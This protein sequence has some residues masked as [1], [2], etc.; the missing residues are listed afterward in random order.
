MINVR[1]GFIWDVVPNPVTGIA[2]SADD[3]HLKNMGL[4]PPRDTTPLAREDWNGTLEGLLLT[5]DPQWSIQ[6]RLKLVMCVARGYS[7]QTDVAIKIQIWLDNIIEEADWKVS[8]GIGQTMRQFNVSK[9]YATAMIVGV[10]FRP[11]SE[12]W[13]KFVEEVCPKIEALI[14]EYHPPRPTLRVW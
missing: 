2:L 5:I 6:D 11:Q 8:N 4:T 13:K 9:L 12:F 1:G 14:R 3:P 10:H 7:L